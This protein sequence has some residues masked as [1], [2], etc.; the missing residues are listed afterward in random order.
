MLDRI[1]QA[2]CRTVAFFFFF[3]NSPSYCCTPDPDH[4]PQVIGSQGP[5]NSV[6]GHQKQ[7]TELIYTVLSL[8]ACGREPAATLG[9]DSSAEASAL[10]LS[11]SLGCS[12][13][14]YP[15]QGGWGGSSTSVQQVKPGKG[16]LFSLGGIKYQLWD[17]PSVWGLRSRAS[18][19]PYPTWVTSSL[20]YSLI[21][22]PPLCTRENSKVTELNLSLLKL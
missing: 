14:R 7:L 20:S 16:F 6:C 18:T 8:R 9:Q 21:L 22:S 2:S 11:S 17:A 3:Y 19:P 15:V 13:G 12:M 1:Q 5:R 4:S 10:L